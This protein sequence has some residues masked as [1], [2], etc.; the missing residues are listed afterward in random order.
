MKVLEKNPAGYAGPVL[1][2]ERS[3]GL[4]DRVTAAFRAAAKA[5]KA[6]AGDSL[7]LA[8]RLVNL[9]TLQPKEKRPEG[10]KIEEITA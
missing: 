8:R 4:G 6:S 5:E 10:I 3:L 1:G 2:F 7:A 9:A